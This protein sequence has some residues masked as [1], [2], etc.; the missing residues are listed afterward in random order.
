[1]FFKF[2]DIFKFCLERV[3][4]LLSYKD[5]ITV[6]DIVSPS[7]AQQVELKLEF[8]KWSKLAKNKF[9]PLF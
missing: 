6:G 7:V 9:S 8:V 1:M 2:L 3:S 5:K 4:F